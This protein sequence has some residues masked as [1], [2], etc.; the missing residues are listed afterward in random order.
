MQS[1]I[2]RQVLPPQLAEPA[3]EYTRPVGTLESGLPDARLL[4]RGVCRHLA[5]LGYASLTEFTLRSGR[6]TDVIAL[7]PGG[8][9]VIVEVKSSIEDFRS[10]NKWPDY[11]DYCDLFYFA[12]PAGFPQELIPEEVGLMAADP[13]DAQVLRISPLSKLNAARRKSLA[14]RFAVA[15]AQR[16]SL[17]TDP[18]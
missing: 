16:L 8:Q 12:V 6:R 2:V 4:A 17:L 7:E 11:L 5:E 3:D 10:D 1:R 15:A 18:R 14:L 13:Y 9:V